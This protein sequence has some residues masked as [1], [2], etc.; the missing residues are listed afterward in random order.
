MDSGIYMAIKRLTGIIGASIWRVLVYLSLELRKEKEVAEPSTHMSGAG[1]GSSARPVPSVT[2]P[3]TFIYSGI[4]ALVIGALWILLQPKILLDYHYNQGVLAATHLFVLAWMAPATFGALYQMVPVA[5][6]TRLQHPFLAWVHWALHCLGAGG[7]IVSFFTDST[8][9][10]VIFAIF[11]I[12][13]VLLMFGNLLLS[14]AH[15]QWRSPTGIAIACAIAWLLATVM[16]GGFIVWNKVFGIH[17]FEPIAQ[18]HAHAHMG[19]LGFFLLLIMGVAYKLV[20]MFV[21]SAIQKPWRAWTSI[22]SFN[23]GLAGLVPAILTNS[24]WKLLFTGIIGF[25]WLVFGWETSSILRL[26]KRRDLSGELKFFFTAIFGLMSIVFLIACI[27]SV[28][29]LALTPWVGRLEN[30][31]GILGIAGVVTAGLI[32][33]LYK[34]VPFLVWYKRYSRHIGRKGVPAIKDLYSPAIQKGGFLCL[35]VGLVWTAAGVVLDS[36]LSTL[37]AWGVYTCGICLFAVNMART[38][39]YGTKSTHLNPAC[40]RQMKREYVI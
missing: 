11:I 23:L 21:L 16:A 33:M 19:V 26:R 15:G 2:L 37:L 24:H 28:P 32:G 8:R 27:L 36:L 20:P 5:L 12:T 22:I 14:M 25:S 35:L 40:P 4:L 10:A 3:L 13:G 1:A 18:M 6:D 30:V 17:P 7:L 29:G 9:S 38:A 39:I 31:Y 34:I